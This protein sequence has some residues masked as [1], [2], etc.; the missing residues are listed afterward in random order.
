[1]ASRN[2]WHLAV[3]ARRPDE[4]WDTLVIDLESGRMDGN[5][6][7]TMEIHWDFG[8]IDVLQPF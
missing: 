6:S 8:E 7:K 5:A 4:R 1:M 2:P 3:S